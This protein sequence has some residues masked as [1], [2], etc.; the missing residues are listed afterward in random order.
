[1]WCLYHYA[2]QD[3]RRFGLEHGGQL[4]PYEMTTAW[5][6]GLD[7]R[8]YLTDELKGVIAPILVALTMDI[9]VADSA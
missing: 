1:V 3:G 8:T 6:T 4:V 2:E 7:A 5:L 9:A